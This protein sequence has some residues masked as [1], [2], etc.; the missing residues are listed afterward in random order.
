MQ[1]L[2]AEG[3]IFLAA[4]GVH[5]VDDPPG[6]MELCRHAVGLNDTFSE[7]IWSSFGMLVDTNMGIVLF[8]F[9]HG[10]PDD[11]DDAG[12]DDDDDDHDV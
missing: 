2:G 9:P 3:F 1:R 8:A 7:R 5:N 4:E 12:D 11:P 10:F 6:A